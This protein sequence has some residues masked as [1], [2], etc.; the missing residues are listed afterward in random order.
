MMKN[1]NALPIVLL[2]ASACAFGGTAHP[3][4]FK[5]DMA[6]NSIVYARDDATPLWRNDSCEHDTC[7]SLKWKDIKLPDWIKPEAKDTV[8]NF[9]IELT[10]RFTP[11]ATILCTRGYYSAQHGG[12]SHYSYKGVSI[13][14][15]TTGVHEDPLSQ[16]EHKMRELSLLEKQQRVLS[17]LCKF[18]TT[19]NTGTGEG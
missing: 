6:N 12:S 18:L 2:I 1:Y 13:A 3:M 9:C 10:T 15:P 17:Y 14:F 16:L 19:N 11:A 4:M 7:T 5:C 8:E